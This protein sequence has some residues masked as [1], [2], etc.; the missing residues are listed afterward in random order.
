MRSLALALCL[1]T[2]AQ[3]AMLGNV[4]V[5]N[6]RAPDCSSLE[7]L[8]ASV[9][10]GCTTDDERAI[11]IYNV[12]RYL[13]YHHAYPTEVGGIG[14][15]KMINVYGWGL[16]GGQHS[17]Q[18]AIWEKAGFKW[19]YRGW[20]RP[21]HTTVECFYGG[22]WHYL[23]TFLK[24]Y[25]WTPDTQAPGGRTIA[26]QEDIKANPAL[27]TDGFVMDQERKVC[28]H[29]DNRF[30]YLRD[31]VNWTAP[32]FMVC[33]DTLPGVLS[34]VRSSRNAGSGRG[35]SSI[36]FDDPG[37]S[38]DVNLGIGYA[39]TLDWN[40]VEGA[41]FFRGRKQPP[42]HTCGDK[43]FRNCPAI[44]PLL[45]P[46]RA[47][48]RART[49]SNGTLTFKP[50]MANDAFLSS[51]LQA[52]NV[53]WKGG[54]L[55]PEDAGKPASFAV[56]MASPYVVARASAAIAS[57]GAK[58]EVSLDGGKTWKP[59]AVGDLTPV[60]KGAYRYLVRVAFTKPITAIELTSVVQHNQEALPYLAPG[61]N[62]IA[63]SAD[64]LKKL[65]KSRLAV[66]YAYCLGSRSQTPEQVYERGAEIARAH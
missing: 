38:T 36:R 37:Y 65:G 30:E 32:A 39:L 49:Y 61:K 7:A 43:D 27:V 28:Y 16:C 9:T 31:K 50:H 6:D 44:G 26:S 1:A 46:Y 57:E 53:A 24:F 21:G 4:K 29:K 42:R 25:V 45:E 10:R 19:R 34:G 62:T 5:V 58:A 66:T 41:W 3:A 17:V 63:I 54:A 11:A 51:L 52:D 33:G 20:S 8:V 13:Y 59:A 18:A 55:C 15:L 60:V 40:K 56:E 48:G 22:R 23:D 12:C 47:L 2:A 35:W 14:A 64:G